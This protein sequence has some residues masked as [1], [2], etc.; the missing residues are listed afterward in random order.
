[1][2]SASCRGTAGRTREAVV[3]AGGFG[4]RLAH[5]VPDVCKPMAPVAGEPFLRRVLD[6]L[7]AAGFARIVIAD[8]YRREQIEGYFMGT[9]RGLEVDYSPEDVPLLTGGAVKRAL[10]LCTQPEVF[11]LN[12]DT[13]LDA[14]FD[15]ME[16]KLSMHPGASCCIAAK[17]MADFDR[18]GTLD[19]A[20]DGRI[21]AFSEKAPCA[22]GLVNGGTYF[23]RR[24]A[25]EAE[26]DVFSLETDWF[27][28]V[29]A[30]GALVACEAQGGFIDIGVPEDYERAQTMFAGAG[31]SHRLALFDR[32]G[33]IN[34][35][36]CHMHRIEDCVLIEPTVEVLRRYTDD[37]AWRVAVVT[38]QAGIAKGLYSVGDMRLLHRQM[39]E[40]LRERGVEVDAWY[41]CPHHPDY[42][43]E[44]SCRK[45]APGMLQRAMRDFRANPA[46][47]IMFGDSEKDRRA[48]KKSDVAFF[49]VGQ[50]LQDLLK[51]GGLRPDALDMC[52][53][54]HIRNNQK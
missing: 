12:G 20:P 2:N 9:Y 19:I 5:V 36:T 4:T 38:N 46:G 43:G 8:G 54:M 47:C 30:D 18:Y 35:D 10:R 14:D 22:D 53:R 48:A 37:P 31:D 7:D 29:V 41:F 39:A 33:T 15:A 21:R 34:I 3:L 24:D 1:M 51:M 13:W 42:T 27:A 28:R 44:C 26:P 45:P 11:V 6:Q 16:E 49:E 52:D 25:L 40:M 17:R 23:I 50:S 32:D